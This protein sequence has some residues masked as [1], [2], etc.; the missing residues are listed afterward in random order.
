MLVA[1]LD[2]MPSDI[3]TQYCKDNGTIVLA[4]EPRSH[5][6]SK[7]IEQHYMRLSQKETCRGVKNRLHEQRDRSANKIV[8]PTK[9]ENPP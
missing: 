2:V 8:E 9:N 6:K 3:M 1:E 5:Q 7:H 4:K